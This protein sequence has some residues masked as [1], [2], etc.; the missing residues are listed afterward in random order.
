[1]GNNTIRG[2]D[3]ND[4]IDGRGGDDSID[5]GD[6]D[7]SMTGGLGNDTFILSSGN[8][9]IT[10][11][12]S[13]TDFIDHHSFGIGSQDIIIVSGTST[14]IN[15]TGGTLT[16]DGVTNIDGG[17][18]I[19]AAPTVSGSGNVTATEDIPY[20][21]SA[22][23]F[24]FSD[25]NSNDDLASITIKSIN[26]PV[27]GSLLLDGIAVTNDQVI[28]RADIDAGKFTFVSATDNHTDSPSFNY[29]VSDGLAESNEVSMTINVA[30]DPIESASATAS[31]DFLG[32]VLSLGISSFNL[33]N[34]DQLFIDGLPDKTA[35]YS[36]EN[37]HINNDDVLGTSGNDSVEIT[38]WNLSELK[39]SSEKML[40][41]SFDLNVRLIQDGQTYTETFT[42]SQI[43]GVTYY[44]TAGDGTAGSDF[45]WLDSSTAGND[46]NF[47]AGDGN[48][49]IYRYSTGGAYQNGVSG[50]ADNDVIIIDTQT[51]GSAGANI[52]KGGSDVNDYDIVYGYSGDSASSAKES[53]T[54]D[55]GSGEL[56]GGD[57]D[58]VLNA[59]YGNMRVDGG[60][61]IDLVSYISATAVI[62]DLQLEKTYL[63]DVSSTLK[64][65]VYNIENILGSNNN[66]ELYGDAG[67]NTIRGV[68]GN[69]II[70][71]RDG[72]DSIDGGDG[73]DSMTGGLGNDTFVLSLGNDVISDFTDG[74]DWIDLR[75][76]G[77]TFADLT[78]S[79]QGSDTKITSSLGGFDTSSIT[80]QNYTG[81][82]G[83][84]N[85]IEGNLAPY[86][87]TISSNTIDENLAAGIQIGVLSA[88]DNAGDITSLVFTEVSDTGSKFYISGNILYADDTFDYETATSYTIGIKVQDASGANN[89]ETLTIYVNDR[90]DPPV[91]NPDSGTVAEDS[92]SVTINLL[93]NDEDL[94]NDSF[95]IQSLITPGN[96]AV[97]NNNDGTVT[98]TPNQDFNGVD[99]FEYTITDTNGG[100]STATVTINVTP[101]NDAPVA[102]NDTFSTDIDTTIEIS[103]N[104]IV[105]ND[106]D[107]DNTSSDLYIVL[108]IDNDGVF[109]ATSVG[110]QDIAISDSSGPFV[111]DPSNQYGAYSQVG[112]DALHNINYQLSDGEFT[113]TGLITVT[114]DRLLYHPSVTDESVSIDQGG[115]VSLSFAT[116][117]SNDSNPGTGTL[118]ITS[119]ST[120]VY[121]DLGGAQIGGTFTVNASGFTFDT[122]TDFDSLG[123]GESYILPI[124]YVVSNTEGNR[125]GHV[126]ITINGLN[127]APMVVNDT[128]NITENE[129]L[130]L[131]R[132]SLAGDDL[133]GD[134]N[135]SDVDVNDQLTYIVDTNSDGT[136]DPLVDLVL[137][138][139]FDKEE[140]DFRDT[141]DYL[142]QGES[143]TIQYAYQVSDGIETKYGDLN[144]V[145]AGVNDVPV[146]EDDLFVG[147]KSI[148][149][150]EVLTVS[151]A[152]GVLANDADPE[153]DSIIA[154]LDSGPAN[155]TLTLNQ[156]GSFTYTPSLT[157]S[158]EDTF[159]YRAED[160]NDSNSYTIGYVTINVLPLNIIGS[161]VR[162]DFIVGSA[163][164][165]ILNGKS[166]NDLLIGGAG[167]DIFIA[168]TGDG[169]DVMDGGTGED[170][171]DASAVT[172]SMVINL[173]TESLISNGQEDVIRNFE[174]IVA[175]SGNDIITG[176]DQNNALYGG[177]GTDVLSGGLGNDLLAPGLGLNNIVDGGDG[178]DILSFEDLDLGN[179]ILEINFLTHEA[180]LVDLD[181][182]VLLSVSF[183]NIEEI[184]G[185]NSAGSVILILGEDDP[186]SYES[187]S[188]DTI[189]L[190]ALSENGFVDGST[191]DAGGQ[192]DSLL[193]FDL[194]TIDA[195]QAGYVTSGVKID[196]EM[197]KLHTSILI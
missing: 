94:E 138:S 90:N 53:L 127:D 76:I 110:A 10:D 34:G 71:G 80:L 126:E 26:F 177:A 139:S 22:S 120:D 168:T 187:I 165:D 142:D 152:E 178:I 132:K 128:I 11:F 107:V 158:G 50:G 192:G 46:A 111:F 16:L 135:D 77:L 1:A 56:Y 17:D 62:V 149:S 159:V 41:S 173:V 21:F 191:I 86:N 101:V 108:D 68:D 72:D 141:Y 40:T 147:A 102:T 169:N 3:G 99:T 27:G 116:L 190:V 195:G 31:T 5:G 20:T 7:D 23:E 157:F 89:T 60:A 153:S 185:P 130:T 44:D 42:V 186:I 58:D 182:Q 98:Y 55:Y 163:G 148:M 146:V 96:G 38:N 65:D 175:G 84:S 88:T 112:T 106:I 6:G 51:N 36:R 4:I 193:A 32:S 57:G 170:T 15:Y 167:N 119:S 136:F 115:S 52:I 74:S 180:K 150:G 45:Y 49:F 85:V 134:I 145:I 47:N 166:L 109:D 196:L 67:N 87:I 29:T 131:T 75:D 137:D 9:H 59:S 171:L 160:A 79:T 181:S 189:D 172:D 194:K 103:F 78:V 143:V 105:G 118:S 81:S 123:L 82:F 8:D 95:S 28:S 179:N 140:F 12:Q 129:V 155:G 30:A 156:D 64:D 114:V 176:N 69:D 13:G 39:I 48:D 54:G 151:A 25:A 162:E 174:N 133:N 100:S 14:V 184:H 121:I 154:T 125:I 37:V 161:S 183:S 18:F 33:G 104:D 117:L 73:D 61:G 164:N 2:V 197:K 144:I 92:G 63:N 19:N 91:A 188:N 97:S 83:V 122:G 43:A 35:L 66:D 24:N 93:A 113:S 70:D 124:A